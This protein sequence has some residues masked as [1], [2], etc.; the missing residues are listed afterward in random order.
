MKKALNTQEQQIALGRSEYVQTQ[1]LMGVGS[2]SAGKLAKLLQN[3]EKSVTV[4]TD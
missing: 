2:I 4:F 1:L 3:H